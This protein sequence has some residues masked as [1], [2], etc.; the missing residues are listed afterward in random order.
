[1]PGHCH[2]KTHYEGHAC[3]LCRLSLILYSVH[4]KC[5]M[6]IELYFGNILLT[7][8]HIIPLCMIKLQLSLHIDST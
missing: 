5:S 8:Y 4:L 6:I 2:E 7:T 1:M 3:T